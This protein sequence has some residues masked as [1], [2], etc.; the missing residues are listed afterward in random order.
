MQKARYHPL[1]R[2]LVTLAIAA[3]LT[4][5]MAPSAMAD[6]YLKNADFSEGSQLW[7]G[8][9]QAA[10]LKPDGTEGQE[11]DP[12]VIPV[13]RVS[14]S[15][16][17]WHQVY[18]EF[19]VRNAPNSFH[20]SVQVYAS[21]DFKRS[22]HAEDYVSDDYIPNADFVLRMMPDYADHTSDLKPGEWVTVD[23][24]A[25]PY[26]ASEDRSI[27]FFFPPG[28]GVI[29]IKNPSVTPPAAQ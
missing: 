3:L 25:R 28:E 19:E 22:T 21:I 9:G 17:G 7:R 8:D 15:R 18:Q 16:G 6:N 20:V 4:M 26:E 11:G 13:I 27:F 12:G 29:Y 23:T 1:M 14:L 10:F 5:G 24:V 2:F